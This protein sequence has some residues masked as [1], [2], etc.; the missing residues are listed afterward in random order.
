M[1]YIYDKTRIGNQIRQRRQALGLTQEQAAERIEKSLVFYSRIELGQIGMSFET[2][3]DICNAFDMTPDEV[4][5]ESKS[6]STLA[7]IEWLSKRIANL[8]PKKQQ[9]VIDFIKVYLRDETGNEG[10]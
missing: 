8:P 4:L 7:N 1:A 10:N 6:D 3:F 5:L 9:T 2:L